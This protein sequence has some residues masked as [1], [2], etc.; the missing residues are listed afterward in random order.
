MK[1]VI[2]WAIIAIALAITAWVVPGIS[3]VGENSWI[4]VLI[5][6]AVFGLVNAVVRPILTMLS[7]GFIVLTLG[8]FLLVINAA[9]FGLTSWLSL[10]IFGQGIYVDGFLPALFGSIVVSIVSFALSLLLPDDNP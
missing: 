7:C 4:A 10:N 5:A 8:L 3:V 6:A 2:R 1:L 9:L